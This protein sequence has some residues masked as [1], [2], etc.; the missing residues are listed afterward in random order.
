ME[1]LPKVGDVRGRGLMIGIELVKNKRSKQ[2]AKEEAA[3]VKD[4]VFREGI[5]IGTGGI[6]KNVIRIQ[7]PL[8]ITEGDAEALLAAL[9]KTFKAI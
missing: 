4:E 1:D 3:R 6:R 5:I 7:P 9:E 2:P 8:V